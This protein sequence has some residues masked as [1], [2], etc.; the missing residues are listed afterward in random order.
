MKTFYLLRHEDVHG[1]SGI[2][3]VAEGVIFD[4]GICAMTWLSQISTVTNF[5]GIRDVAKLHSHEGKTEVVV[6]GNRRQS[7]L[8]A[9]CRELAKIKKI[10]SA[11]GVA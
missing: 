5:R 10:T 9:Q 6:E 7:K 1:N 2:G 4:S 3:V 11:K 8:Y